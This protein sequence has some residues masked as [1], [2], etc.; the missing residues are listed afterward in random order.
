MQRFR[1]DDF[2]IP[3]LRQ[4]L[5]VIN[6]TIVRCQGDVKLTNPLCS[7]VTYSII[8]GPA[9]IVSGQGTNIVTLKSTANGTAILRATSG[10]YEDEK[11]ISMSLTPPTINY[12]QKQIVCQNSR[13]YFYGAVA[14]IP[15]TGN[16]YDWYSKD[17][18]N[19][20]NPYVLRQTGLGNTADFPLGNNGKVAKYYTIRVIANTACGP[21]QSIDVEGYLYAPACNN[22][23]RIA[24]TPNP[25][26]N[27]MTLTLLNNEGNVETDNNKNIKEVIIT[28]KLGTVLI[29]KK[30]PNG[31]KTST[32]NITSLKTDIYFVKVWDGEL[33]VTT[34]LSKQ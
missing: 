26:Q 16:N 30:M 5:A 25:T 1:A 4:A 34:T 17:M 23:A 6:T 24:I 12:T 14:E 11:S 8:S 22:S 15:S 18:S 33:W 13:H 9:T 10:N 3:K 19:A 7:P 20:S 21:Q 2:Q 27:N 28:D 29:A 32:I 31:Q